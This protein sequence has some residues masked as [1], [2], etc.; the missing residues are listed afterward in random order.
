MQASVV[1]NL[2]REKE[3][4]LW[5]AKRKH[6]QLHYFYVASVSKGEICIKNEFGKFSK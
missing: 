4:H 3:N 5:F 1:V 6:V 2:A